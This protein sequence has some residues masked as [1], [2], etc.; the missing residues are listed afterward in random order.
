M[1]PGL[2]NSTCNV[3]LVIF[4]LSFSVWS[5]PTPD[6]LQAALAFWRKTVDEGKANEYIEKCEER[7]RQIG[8]AVSVVG[9]K[10]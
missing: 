5:L 4:G 6:E 9:Y 2:Y 10:Q 1:F 8:C 3:V 7:R